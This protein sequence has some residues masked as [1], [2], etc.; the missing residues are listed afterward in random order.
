MLLWIVL[1][2]GK[3]KE[4]CAWDSCISSLIPSNDANDTSATAAYKDQRSVIRFEP[5]KL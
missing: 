4:I 3:D 5:R 2:K 1:E